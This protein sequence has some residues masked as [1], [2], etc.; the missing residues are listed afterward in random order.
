MRAGRAGVLAKKNVKQREE[1]K[2][3]KDVGLKKTEM[4]RIPKKTKMTSVVH[5]PMI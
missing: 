3:H 5:F 2:K 4:G 1:Q